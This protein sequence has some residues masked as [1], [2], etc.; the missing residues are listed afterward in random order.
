[1]IFRRS[2]RSQHAGWFPP[3]PGPVPPMP[4]IDE[5][6]IHANEGSRW[7]VVQV[8]SDG[9]NPGPWM[10]LMEAE[11][12]YWRPLQGS[13]LTW[14]PLEDEG[15]PEVRFVSPEHVAHYIRPERNH[16]P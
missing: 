7:R 14:E 9:C 15:A 5:L 10:A 4:H 16:T 12:D 1:M 13:G 2:R 6:F 11:V 3:T 8:V